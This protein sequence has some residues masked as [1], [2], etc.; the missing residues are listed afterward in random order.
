MR[1][2]WVPPRGVEDAVAFLTAHGGLDSTVFNERL[3]AQVT[4]DAAV[5][6]EDDVLL[7]TVTVKEQ[8]A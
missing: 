7:M 3:L 1:G 6:L 4:Q 8:P 5:G 2:R